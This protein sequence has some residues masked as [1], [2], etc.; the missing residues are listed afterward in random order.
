MLLIS[1][2]Y[3][4]EIETDTKTIYNSGVVFDGE[5]I[6]I[7]F[8]PQIINLP[9]HTISFGK[10]YK[11]LRRFGRGF[12]SIGADLKEYLHCIVTDKFRIYIKSSTG[13]VL[14]TDKDFEL[15]L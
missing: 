6:Q 4:W 14:I 1:E 7:R 3:K 13:E 10:E 12:M 11:F 8:I 15:Y 2:Y 9:K 5:V